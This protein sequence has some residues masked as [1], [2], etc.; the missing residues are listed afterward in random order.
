MQISICL[1]FLIT[2]INCDNFNINRVLQCV[3]QNQAACQSW[4]EESYL[5][6]NTNLWS[7]YCFSNNTYVLTR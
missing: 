7:F 2:L 4:K 5:D 6:Y 3:N 1:F